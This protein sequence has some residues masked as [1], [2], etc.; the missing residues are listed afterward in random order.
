IALINTL[1]NTIGG[2]NV[3]DDNQNVDVLSGNIIAGNGFGSFTRTQLF[4]TGKVGISRSLVTDS[5]L[6]VAAGV[7]CNDLSYRAVVSQQL[8]NGVAF[9]GAPQQLVLSTF[10]A[11]GN[12]TETGPVNL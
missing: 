4:S 11:T 1:G 12:S 8:Y 6:S 3:L 9:P 5:Y 10:D 7:F 2:T